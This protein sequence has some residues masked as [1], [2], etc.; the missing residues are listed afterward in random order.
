MAD[1]TEAIVLNEKVYG[2]VLKRRVQCNSNESIW[3]HYET[4]MKL[5]LHLGFGLRKQIKERNFSSLGLSEGRVGQ[6][7]WPSLDSARLH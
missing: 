5:T 6:T 3:H 4:L 7:C 1:D 2:N